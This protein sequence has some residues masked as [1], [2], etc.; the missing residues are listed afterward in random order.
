MYNQKSTLVSKAKMDYHNKGKW[1]PW[2][3]Q[4]KSA[5]QEHFLSFLGRPIFGPKRRPHQQGWSPGRRRHQTSGKRRARR[6]SP[7]QARHDVSPQHGSAPAGLQAAPGSYPSP[8]SEPL[9]KKYSRYCVGLIKGKLM[10]PRINQSQCALPVAISTRPINY[11]CSSF[12]NGPRPWL[13]IARHPCIAENA[14]RCFLRTQKVLYNL[15]LP[16]H[17]STR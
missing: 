1:A 9:S 12:V 14:M 2:P 3:L 17:Y 4:K 10:T 5:S 11:S 13:I 16:L 8:I 15:L 6:T 7:A